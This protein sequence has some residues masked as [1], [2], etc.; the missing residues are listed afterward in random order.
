[1]RLD[2]RLRLIDTPFVPSLFKRACICCSR[3]VGRCSV[4]PDEDLRPAQDPRPLRCTH[5]KPNLKLPWYR[6][7]R[8]STSKLEGPAS[9]PPIIADRLLQQRLQRC[10]IVR[11]RQTRPQQV[12]QLVRQQ[13]FASSAHIHLR[14]GPAAP[15]LEQEAR[16]RRL[17]RLGARQ[18]AERRGVMESAQGRGYR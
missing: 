17:S 5:S 15:P 2:L 12:I 1:M 6:E 10:S 7:F 8:N 9:L 16:C 11:T 3:L 4:L 14:A 18:G 13:A